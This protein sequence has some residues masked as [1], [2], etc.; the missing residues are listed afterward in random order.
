MHEFS[1]HTVIAQCIDFYLDINVCTFICLF[2]RGK[3]F[4]KVFASE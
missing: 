1:Y 3:G 2:F 4:Q